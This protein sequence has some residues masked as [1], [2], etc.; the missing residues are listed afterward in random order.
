M[1]DHTPFWA[2]QM[3]AVIMHRFHKLEH[4]LEHLVLR[5][6]RAIIDRI[7]LSDEGGLSDEQQAHLDEIYALATADVKKIDQALETGTAATRAFKGV[8]P[9]K[10]IDEALEAVK[11]ASTRTDSIIAD[12]ASLKQQLADALANVTL[13][14]DVQAKIDSIFDIESSDAAK[15]DAALNTNVPPPEP[16]PVV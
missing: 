7:G 16:A 13:P 1:H 14:A 11:A 9:M 8:E 6:G 3:Q 4:E 15:I 10:T 5:V 2:L 12:R